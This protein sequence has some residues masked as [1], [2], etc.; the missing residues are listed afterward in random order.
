MY[1]TKKLETVLVDGKYKLVEVEEIDLGEDFLASRSQRAPVELTDE[2]IKEQEEIDRQYL[3]YKAEKRV[4]N[5]IAKEK[6]EEKKRLAMIKQAVKKL[7][8]ERRKP[9]ALKAMVKAFPEKSEGKIAEFLKPRMN[10]LSK[11]SVAQIDLFVARLRAK[12]PPH[13]QSS[14]QQNR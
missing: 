7:E 9:Y 10:L 1:I 13:T 3:E 2:L 5:K 14:L 11:Q 4:T 6:R 12:N 8:I